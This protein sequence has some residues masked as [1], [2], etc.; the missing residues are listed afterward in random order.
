M[1]MQRIN[2]KQDLGQNRSVW[3]DFHINCKNSLSS[4]FL[5]EE[6][7]LE[8]TAS[9]NK[10]LDFSTLPTIDLPTPNLNQSV[11]FFDILERRRSAQAFQS[12]EI[13]QQI[14]ST[15]LF[16]TCGIVKRDETLHTAWRT[17]PSA[18]GLY[19]IDLFFYMAT[20]HL[21]PSGIYHYNPERHAVSIIEKQD[22]KDFLLEATFDNEQIRQAALVF[23]FALVPER[24]TYKYGDRGYRYALL[25]AG[26]M[27]QNLNLCA[28][29]L[30]FRSLNF[31]GYR[32]AM[33]DN[34]LHFDGCSISIIYI[35]L[36]G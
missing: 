19:P 35:T 24:A 11:D 28:T 34:M 18:G 23:F 32:D 15:L 17:S 3:Q 29:A 36:V 33:I 1:V 16:C 9:I 8:W 25:E 4:F 10:C 6:E 13:D 2:L 31:G 5:S 7:A 14:L 26:H 20:D 30:N 21:F 12:I 27:A 22:K